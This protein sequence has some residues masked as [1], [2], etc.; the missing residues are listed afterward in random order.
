MDEI[1]YSVAKALENEDAK[2]TFSY[3]EE[4]LKLTLLRL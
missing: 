2:V 3:K 1:F 4:V